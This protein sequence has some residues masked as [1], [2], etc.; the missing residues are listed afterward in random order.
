RNQGIRMARDPGQQLD[1]DQDAVHEQSGSRGL[2]AARDM[3]QEM[4]PLAVAVTMQ[5]LPSRYCGS[6]IEARDSV[7]Y[8]GRF[9]PRSPHHGSFPRHNRTRARG[10]P[11]KPA[12]TGCGA[13][14]RAWLSVTQ[15][16]CRETGHRLLGGRCIANAGKSTTVEATGPTRR[17]SATSDTGE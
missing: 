10:W 11:L 16:V 17:G 13:S 15:S 4:D 1:D 14:A 5:S 8:A 6:S 7:V 12:T 9:D 3:P 2:D